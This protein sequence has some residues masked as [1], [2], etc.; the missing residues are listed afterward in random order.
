MGK[1]R[2]FGRYRR[3][4]EDLSCILSISISILG[5]MIVCSAISLAG[6]IAVLPAY[7]EPDSRILDPAIHLNLA[8]RLTGLKK[9][10]EALQE[11]NKAL[12]ENP[13]YYDAWYQGA[14]IFQ[15]EGRRKEAIV[16]YKR[17]LN[18]RPDYLGARINLGS[19]F[20]QE[21]RIQE[22]EDQYRKVISENFN[23]FDAH[24]NLANL[25]IDR[26]R[27]KEAVTEL[28]ICIKFQPTNAW[29]HNNLGVIYQRGQYLE[30]A[31]EEFRKASNLEPA[32]TRFV[33]NL[34]LVRDALKNGEMKK[35]LMPEEEPID[36]SQVKES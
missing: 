3:C 8:K 21:G 16:R 29:A 9:Y 31:E 24:F 2:I 4:K 1:A 27:L 22:A 10:K 28:N 30:E 5:V 33:E 17:L 32:N 12:I 34:E 11:V 26:E 6:S 7:S 25:L 19:L 14:I 13:D 23:S 18:R 15:L 20:R 36:P 35:K